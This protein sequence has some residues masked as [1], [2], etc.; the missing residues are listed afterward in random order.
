[1]SIQANKDILFP[2]KKY[3][4]NLPIARSLDYPSPLMADHDALSL[5][6]N[7]S[8]DFTSAIERNLAVMAK[9]VLSKL[10][11]TVST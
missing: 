2:W 3:N 7:E 6:Y 4:S 10:K 1:M 8:K 11:N 5:F 9:C